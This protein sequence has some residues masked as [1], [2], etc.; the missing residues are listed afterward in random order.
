MPSAIWNHAYFSIALRSF[1][2][3]A[4]ACAAAVG[5]ATA[6]VAAAMAAAVGGR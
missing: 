6:A 1:A 3:T 5:C 4:R 2:A